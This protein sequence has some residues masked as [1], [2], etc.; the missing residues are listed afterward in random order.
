MA[1]GLATLNVLEQQS[2]WKKL[3][4]LGAHWQQLL[5]PILEAEREAG[6]PISFTRCASIFWLCFG[7]TEQPRSYAAIPE[8]GDQ[9]YARFFNALLEQGIMIA[10]SAYEVGFISLAMTTQDLEFAAQGFKQALQLSR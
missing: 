2:G 4:Q 1:A 7:A 10:P 8:G 9:R 6:H 3:E 5:E